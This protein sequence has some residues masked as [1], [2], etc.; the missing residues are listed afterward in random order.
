MGGA[1]G[2]RATRLLPRDPLR[3]FPRFFSPANF[4]GPVPGGR[5]RRGACKFPLQA[6]ETADPRPGSPRPPPPRPRTR[7]RFGSGKAL[8]FPN[9]PPP[10]G[11]PGRG[12]APAARPARGPQRKKLIIDRV[13]GVAGAPG[14]QRAR[15]RAGLRGG[16]ARAHLRAPQ[17]S[18]TIP[19][20]WRRSGS[21]SR[22]GAGG[23][24][25]MCCGLDCVSLGS[26]RAGNGAAAAGPAPGAAGRRGGGSR[27]PLGP[28]SRRRRC[29]PEPRG[30]RRGGRGPSPRLGPA[31]RAPRAVSPAS[32][33]LP[34]L[35]SPS[36]FLLFGPFLPLLPTLCPPYCFFVTVFS[37]LFSKFTGCSLSFQTGRL[38]PH[39]DGDTRARAGLGP[40]APRA[41]VRLPPSRPPAAAARGAQERSTGTL[42]GSAAPGRP[43]GADSG[44]G[45]AAVGAGGRG[46]RATGPPGPGD[47]AVG[48]ETL[49]AN[50]ETVSR[51]TLPAASRSGRA[52][53]RL[54]PGGAWAPR[55]VSFCPP[56][57]HL[58]RAER[59][60]HRR[61][62]VSLGFVLPPLP[63]L[64]RAAVQ[65]SV[66]CA[67]SPC[68][69]R[70]PPD[71]GAARGAT[72]PNICPSSHWRIHQC[73]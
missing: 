20:R 42:R 2:P 24:A 5:S 4:P 31:A 62:G 71:R 27:R 51:Q 53:G 23:G 7:G 48:R 37:S 44:A 28:E 60:A 16:A 25:S 54:F 68:R 69:P 22:S 63:S 17:L 64:P 66:P 72:R 6:G 49:L 57:A 26:S 29:S 45:A 46:G 41:D 40:D 19:G 47:A 43:R 10:Q 59:R 13:T 21:R 61:Q 18:G 3:H 73:Q 8:V 12:T 30:G 38:R 11:G 70:P 9:Q 14:G 36:F 58:P 1:L 67:L 39:P 33:F 35:L 65:T 55:E 34:P 56:P 50:E 32:S 15:A 52:A